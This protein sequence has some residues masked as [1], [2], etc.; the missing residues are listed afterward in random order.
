MPR[1]HNNLGNAL[2][3]SGRTEDA[4]ASLRRAAKLKPG[5]STVHTN[6]GL[7]LSELGRF[8]EAAASHRTALKLQPGLALAHNN[9]GVALQKAGKLDEAIASFH[10]AI[11]LQPALPEA[12][13]NLADTL[14]LTKPAGESR[15]DPGRY[16]RLEE[17]ISCYRR[18]VEIRP[19]YAEAYVNLGGL[20]SELRR[21]AEAATCFAHARELDPTEG[22][23]VIE[24][25]FARREMCEWKDST[26]DEAAFVRAAQ[27][28]EKGAMAF[29][30]LAIVDDPQL[31]LEAARREARI[32][33]AGKATARW[34]ATKSRDAKI[35][36]GYLSADFQEHATAYL[37]AELIE[38]HDRS[39]FEVQAFSFGQDDRSP[40][41]NRLHQAF[42]RFNDVGSLT[43][44]EAA[45]QI[46]R[47]EIDIAIDL[48]GYTREDRPGILSYRPAPIQVAYLGYPGT[49]GADF[50]DYA[51]V[52]DFVVPAGAARYFSEKLVYLPDCYQVNDTRRVVADRTP[53]R[54]DCGLPAEGFVFCSFNNNYKITPSVFDVWMRLLARV[55]NS[56]LWLL[57][58]NEWA[59]ANL[60]REAQQRGVSPGRLIFAPRLKL[61]EHLARHRL[62]DLFLDTAPVNA[63]TTA[64]D[65]LWVGLPLV[66]CAGKSFVAR[67]AGSLLRA[68][69]MPELITTDLGDYEAL[70]LKL[71]SEPQTL[72]ALRAKL[73]R[74][75]LTYP[76][77]DIDRFR[78]NIEAAYVHMWSTRQRGGEPESFA[79]ERIGQVDPTD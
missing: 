43:D 69:G 56:V 30:F 54:A 8:E 42:D 68:V 72:A 53:S 67:V 10:R 6:L 61:A 21:F 19:G 35:R 13:V 16:A 24:H 65:A 48:K 62:A 60:R 40:M 64:S 75:R 25:V 2:L 73:E 26:T 41:R 27:S 15:E 1:I 20:L 47:A 49:M 63:H 17:A 28:V 66:T 18:A 79:V 58:D 4:V 38:R 59:V 78:R 74:N 22:R 5:L 29:S 52:D 39:R 12:L 9:L 23:A 50:I 31:Q 14:R 45:R 11:E 36:L 33:T 3:A 55:P 77:F 34:P 51:I 46:H 7:A 32:R 70:A 71:A 37:I 44:Q 76:L 57:A